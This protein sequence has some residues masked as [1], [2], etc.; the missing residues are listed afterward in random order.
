LKKKISKC[1]LIF[2][3]CFIISP[4]FKPI[5]INANENHADS[6]T[7]TCQKDDIVLNDLDWEIYRVADITDNNKFERINEFTK[8]PVELNGLTTS[9]LQTAAGTLEAYTKT[10]KIS[11]L[12]TG[13]TDSNGVV[14]F[15]DLE[16]GLYL[17]A[18]ESVI[19]GDTFYMPAPSLIILRDSNETGV[20]WQYNVNA[21]PKLKVL[22]ASMRIYR[23]DGTVKITWTNDDEKNRPDSVT[24]I[25]YKDG[26][27]FD[28]VILSS[29]NNWQHTWPKLSSEYKWNV[30]EEIVPTDYTV[31]YS[32]TDINIKSEFEHDT[33]FIINNTFVQT[34]SQT[35]TQEVKPTIPQTGQLWW[36]VPI[37]SAAGLLAFGTGWKIN[38]S[39][40]NKHEK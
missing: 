10:D 17:V 8:Y 3:I 38:S 40:R 9:Q 4:L 37:L 2:L 14:S 24:A 23:F 32:T 18:G 34:P 1:F 27:K 16:H 39:K 13:T 26:E 28:S 7:I 31:T 19:I 15:N 33:E 6:L 25:L 29:S 35:V 12:R 11:P 36:P 22:P 5:Q 30:T 20:K 21:M